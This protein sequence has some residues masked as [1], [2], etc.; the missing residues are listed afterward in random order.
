MVGFLI[1]Y[2][3]SALGQ[4]GLTV[5]GRIKVEN[6]NLNGAKVLI[7]KDGQRI[8]TM[9]ASGRFEFELDFQAVY[10][11]SFTKDDYVTKKLRFDTHVPDE[12]VE[13]G[14]LPFEF[15][16]SIFK[17]YD[18]VNTVIFNQPVGMISYSETID[19]F[20]Y[21]TDYT[22]S[23]QAQ[24]EEIQEEIEEKIAEEAEAMEEAE[25]AEAKRNKEVS[26]LSSSG[27]KNL[28]SGRFDEAIDDFEKALSLKPDDPEIKAKLDEARK[29][30][31]QQKKQE[32]NK[33]KI[34]DLLTQATD[35]EGKRN[36]PEAK[37]LLEQAQTLAPDDKEVSKRLTD[38]N[39]KI[40]DQEKQ[41]QRFDELVD[42]AKQANQANNYDEAQKLVQEALS[43]KPDDETATQL[44]SQITQAVAVMEEETRKRKEQQ[45]QFDEKVAEADKLL[46]EGKLPEA[47]QAYQAALGIMDDSD[48]RNRLNETDVA[49][50]QQAEEEAKQAEQKKQFDDLVNQ[51]NDHINND[52]LTDASDKVNQ[53]RGLFPEHPQLKDL[54]KRIKDRQDELAQQ[55]EQAQKKKDDFEEF[56]AG[57]NDKLNNGDLD[58]AEEEF[59]KAKDLGLDDSRADDGLKAVSSAREAQLAQAQLEEEKRKQFESLLEQA[60][61][62]LEGGNPEEAKNLYTQAIG[63]MEDDRASKGL[64]KAQKA[65]DDIQAQAAA[66]AE[67]RQRF[68][69]L[70]ASGNSAFG[71]DDLD[72]AEDAFKQALDL[73]EEDEPKQKLEEI[74]A[75]REELSKLAEEAAAQKQAEEEAAAKQAEYDG[76]ITKADESF[77]GGDYEKARD[78]YEKALEV[79]P[80]EVYPKDQLAAIDQK[81]A[82]LEETQ[83][84]AAEQAAIDDEYNKLIAEADK[85]FGKDD[86]D[87]AEDSYKAA[88]GVK[89]ETYPKDQLAAIAAKRE[90]LAT[91]V[92]NAEAAATQAAI[93]DEYNKLIAEADKAFGKDD[94]D[95]AEES[96]K[97]AL[98]VKDETYPKDQLA[99]IAAKREALATEAANAEAAAAQAAVDDEYNK[100]IAEADKAFGKD[101]LDVAEENY[102]AALGVKDEVYPKDQLAAIAAKREALA[103]DAANAEAAA[104]QAATDEE[105][106]KLIAAADKAFGKDDLDAAEESYKAALGVKDE[107]YPKDQL[108]AIAAKREALATDAANAEAAATQAAIDDEYN[109]LIAEADKSFGKDDLDAAEESYKAALGVKDEVYPKD[110]LA[111]IAA[112]R[113][114]LASE[115]ANAEATAAQAAI[116]E[117][118]NKLISEADKAFGKDDLDAAEE[119]YTA[120][121]GVKDEVYPKDQL[122]A[123][124][125]KREALA[126]DAANAEAAAE[127]A[128]TDEEYNKLIAAGDKA[129]GKDDLD[130]AEESYTA[131]LGVKDEVYP[132]DQLAAI[133]AKREALANDAA[134]AEAA[135]A[136]A[137]TDEEYNKL[138]A[139][140]DKAFGKDDLDAAEESYTSALG[141]KDEVY[142]KDQ[143]VAIAAKREALATDAANAEA[144][145][146]QA[147]IDDEYNKLIA[148]ADKSFGKDD[149]DAAEQGYKDA[150]AVKDETYPKDQ[151]AAIAAK[152]QEL[153]DRAAEEAEADTAKER[154]ERFTQLVQDGDKLFDDESWSDAIA[155]Y[156]EALSI[157]ED[158]HPKIQISIAE[159]NLKKDAL[160]AAEEQKRAE[161]DQLMADGNKLFQSNA[162]E[163]SK[164]SYEQ[165]LTIFDEDEPKKRIEKIDQILA[166]RQKQN[167]DAAKALAAEKT[168]NEAKEL[169]DIIQSESKPAKANASP[170][171]GGESGS[172]AAKAS[173]VVVISDP[174]PVARG[175]AGTL[176]EDDV[177]DGIE[178]RVA[179]QAIEGEMEQRQNE[180]AKKYPATKTVEQEKVG[181]SMVT[182]VYIND[183]G[184]VTVYK[185][186]EHNWGGVYYFVDDR[187]TTARYWDH[188]TQ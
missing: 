30:Q 153:A 117:E 52:Q 26:N 141:V 23:I 171:V 86:L 151:L 135:A 34:Q 116:E 82:E 145:A 16:V 144:A 138:I 182:Y 124:A 132:K 103:T 39:S 101:D 54:D 120:A 79:L 29:G 136:Q 68:N 14:F 154:E 6:G 170:T 73:F 83:K 158:D 188:Q 184:F 175:A 168:G 181:N 38:V 56:I 46:E 127:Q 57:G 140:G 84:Q 186:V 43:I 51:A 11:I 118:Y 78:N 161:Y 85:A 121:L 110:Q 45:E 36:F 18:G 137:A 109:K 99:A 104:A 150:L 106:N 129:F 64:D 108:A 128:S 1:C 183:N 61:A 5:S 133:A 94:L 178:K 62:A 142:P 8:K 125:A 77:N 131:A 31:E 111:A 105:Y 21:D 126:T 42:Q 93:D 7:E 92:A 89:D 48:V 134:N 88:L 49:I 146:A 80:D 13:F 147:A 96:Y 25:R 58:G 74:A 100:L 24:I 164:R 75:R 60:D 156:N 33:A 107:V 155:K 148:E 10:I 15:V 12:R 17:Q 41:N 40:Q 130:A 139:A 20:D 143:L 28:S 163:E 76:L 122:A 69:D 53:A 44:Q 185:K 63:V 173:S 81:I 176:S 162:L 113:E 119:S 179:Q 2:A 160:E 87:A 123:I 71:N 3:G 35:E 112:K 102:K 91:E 114:A 98:G 172:S 90:A 159:E 174:K 50:T 97:A 165:A 9:E 66:E 157:K 95:A 187:P 59:N 27:S 166:A 169:T 55:A 180:L 167:A 70:I 177:Y 32:E 149:L 152:R 65:L 19:E 72:A 37:K 4:S 22:K 67:N 115:A 47:K